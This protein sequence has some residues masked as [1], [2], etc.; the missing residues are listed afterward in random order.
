MSLQRYK[1]GL[2]ALRTVLNKIDN[3]MIGKTIDKEEHS[4]IASLRKNYVLMFLAYQLMKQGIEE[5][6]ALE[7]VKKMLDKVPDRVFSMDTNE[8]SLVEQ[9]D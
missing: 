6:K 5:D 2:E 1:S 4:H 3:E 8:I 7:Q 9:L